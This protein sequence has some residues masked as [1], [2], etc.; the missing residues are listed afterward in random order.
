MQ[1]TDCRYYIVISFSYISQACKIRPHMLSAFSVK[2][3]HLNVLG[4]GT[5]KQC[6]WFDSNKTNFRGMEQGSKRIWKGIP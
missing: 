6:T 4:L 1:V 3:E 2:V 5:S